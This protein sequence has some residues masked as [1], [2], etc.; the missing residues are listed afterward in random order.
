MKCLYGRH[1]E[2]S[3]DG[4]HWEFIKFFKNDMCYI[5][6]IPELQEVWK[7]DTYEKVIR[8]LSGWE[9]HYMEIKI[10]FINKH[11][12]SIV[13]PFSSSI[14]LSKKNME[15]YIR[16]KYTDESN[17]PMERLI[18]DLSNE[19]FRAWAKDNELKYFEKRD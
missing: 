6:E 2:I 14:L 9:L 3:V 18:K 11:F 1:L 8:L 7:A 19:D 4:E 5:E 17:A 12:V 10:P 16:I 13:V 15:I